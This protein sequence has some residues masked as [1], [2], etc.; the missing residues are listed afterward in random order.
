MALKECNASKN[1]TSGLMPGECAVY[2]YTVIYILYNI[3]HL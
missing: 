2:I 1:R 3:I